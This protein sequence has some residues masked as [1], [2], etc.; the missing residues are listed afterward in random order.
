MTRP[1]SSNEVLGYIDLSFPCLDS[2]TLFT[3]FTLLLIL[4]VTTPIFLVPRGIS[5]SSHE[6]SH[7][8]RPDGGPDSSLAEYT[9]EERQC[10]SFSVSGK[11][12]PSTSRRGRK[13]ALA[14]EEEH[15]QLSYSQS[16]RRIIS[17]V[18]QKGTTAREQPFDN[19]SIGTLHR[20]LCRATYRV[21]GPLTDKMRWSL[22]WFNCCSSNK[23]LQICQRAPSY[24]S[25]SGS[26]LLQNRMCGGTSCCCN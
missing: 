3:P 19:S 14:P 20:I 11:K 6:C 2:S 4:A 15:P 22:H 1:T 8:W 13:T 17:T 21:S 5:I 7:F 10:F 16:S 18:W 26:S 25:R 9:F 24:C 12:Q 23:L